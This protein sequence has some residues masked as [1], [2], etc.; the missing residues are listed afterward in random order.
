MRYVEKSGN[1]EK[2]RVDQRGRQRRQR[3]G[4]RWNMDTYTH[5]E[6]RMF[7]SKRE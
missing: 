3:G 7:K 4:G 2:D 1:R 5:R 6:K